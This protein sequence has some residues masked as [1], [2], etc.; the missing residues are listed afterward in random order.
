MQDRKL[1]I[2][3]CKHRSDL[4][5]TYKKITWPD[6]MAKLS[7]TKRTA[8]TVAEYKAKNKDDQSAIK[9]VGGFVLGQLTGKS[10]DHRDLSNHKTN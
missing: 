10:I 1:S 4:T 6:L 2:S 7:Q 9:D 8:E 3:V 5:Y